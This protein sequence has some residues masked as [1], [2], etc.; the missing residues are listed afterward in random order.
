M[1]GIAKRLGKKHMEGCRFFPWCGALIEETQCPRHQ[2][3]R[4][5][6]IKGILNTWNI[7][8]T[9]FI[10]S[11]MFPSEKHGTILVGVFSS[12]ISHP[13]QFQGTD[14]LVRKLHFSILLLPWVHGLNHWD[15][16]IWPKEKH[17]CPFLPSSKNYQTWIPKSPKCLN[18]C[19][20]QQ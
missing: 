10:F 20:F 6:S 2:N 7:A 18:K 14:F 16:M 11:E 5:T 3:I 8:R 4:T 9:G 13:N 17:F 19:V 15:L 1:H 12:P